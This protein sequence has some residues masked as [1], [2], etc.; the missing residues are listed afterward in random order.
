MNTTMP[1]PGDGEPSHRGRPSKLTDEL[2]RKFIELFLAGSFREPAC[3]ELGI[4]Y[5]TFSRWM[6]RGRREPDSIYGE[7]R[8]AV[9]AAEARSQ[10]RMLSRIQ[11]ASL[12]DWKAA[13]WMLER[14]YPRRYGPKGGEYGEMKKK[15]ERAEKAMGDLAK[16]LEAAG[17]GHE[18]SGQ[19][20]E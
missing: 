20:P 16:V 15:A 4:G 3:H 13:A 11:A 1:P 6:N 8:L 17:I 7:F 9:G 14:K 2:F 18:L 10:N 19:G 5:T 12:E